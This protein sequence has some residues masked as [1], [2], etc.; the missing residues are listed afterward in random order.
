[1]A[2]NIPSKE[3]KAAIKA[4]NEILKDQEKDVI[5]VVGVTKEDVLENFTN[6]I[7]DFI[8]NDKAADLPDATIDFYNEYI[9]DSGEEEGDDEADAKAK[10]KADAKAKKKAAAKA[11]REANKKPKKEFFVPNESG[12]PKSVVEALGKGGTQKEVLENADSIYVKSGGT[13][14]PGQTKRL[15]ENAVRYLYY[16]GKLEISDAGVYTLK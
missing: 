11:K 7:L 8:E 9:V 5:K 2:K 6:S 16:A 15:F 12:R 4:L 13:S 1:M 3:F 10:E 14:N